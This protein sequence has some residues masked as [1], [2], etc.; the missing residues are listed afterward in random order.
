[1]ATFFITNDAGRGGFVPYA[2][3]TIGDMIS[4]FSGYSYYNDGSEAWF[5]MDNTD[6]DVGTVF[7]DHYNGTVT[8]H[9]V[10]FAVNE[11]MIGGIV[12]LN[13]LINEAGGQYFG[14][15][16][17]NG[18]HDLMHDND[19]AGTVHGGYGDDEIWGNGGND[20]LFGDDGNDYI[21]GDAGNDYISGGAGSD[22]AHF[23]GSSSEYLF[24]RQN[25]G[26]VII[27]D[28]YGRDGT[29]YLT[30]MET[31]SFTNGNYSIDQLT[32][33]V[34]PPQPPPPSPAPAEP[35]NI[36]GTAG[37][38]SLYGNA[39]GNSLFGG[40]GRDTM[41]GGAGKDSF[42]FDTSPKSGRDFIKDFYV[43]QDTIKLDNADFRGIG[44]N[45]KLKA[46]AFFANNTGKA[47]DASDRVIYDK[48]SGKL[49]YDSDGTGAKAGVCFSD[50]N[51]NLKMTAADFFVL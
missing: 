10:G 15:V 46:G 38:D 41:W 40:A 43:P 39:L 45:G 21:G 25:N 16:I 32:P 17:V 50:I 20:A 2:N 9:N 23:A 51:K 4:S 37:N 47:H 3:S 42:M 36:Y 24:A 7:T 49:Y 29:D 27:T 26:D 34:V 11:T 5:D 33:A 22:I 48:D 6:I 12:G 8:T 14:N 44:S 31:F 28:K 30:G 35:V 19:Y 1:M 18:G 13:L